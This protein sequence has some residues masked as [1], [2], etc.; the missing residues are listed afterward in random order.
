[1]YIVVT[2]AAGFIGVESRQGAQRA[3]RDDDHRRRQSR[4]RR[5]VPQPRRLRHRRLPRQG[6]VPR[7]PRRRR[8]RRRHRGGAAP[9]RVLGH[10]GDRRPL[11]DA[12]QLPLLGRRCS[13]IARTTTCRSS[14]RRARRCT[15]AAAMFREERAYEAPLNVYGYSKFLFDQYVR[16]HAARAHRADRRLPLFQRLR[17]ARA[18][19]GA[20]GVGRVALLQPVSRRAAA[21][22]L[23]EGSGGYAAGEQRRDFVRVDDVVKRQPRFPRPS[24]SARAS[25]TSAPAR[26]ATFNDVA[27]ATIN[28]CR[29]ADGEPPRS[30]AELVARRRDRVHADS[31]RR[32]SASTRASRRPTSTRLRAAGY[33]APMLAVD[34]GVR[35]LRRKADFGVAMPSA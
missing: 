20:D 23:F 13:I 33:R 22:S 30:L 34:E 26:A 17:P 6:R 25:S 35:A 10:D 15:A 5:Q 27:C 29:T 4:A 2:G 1:M 28:A 32:S 12:Q 19:Q 14:T 11:H 21:C 16:R 8:L 9:G 7:A 18:A 24:A 3:R 31:R